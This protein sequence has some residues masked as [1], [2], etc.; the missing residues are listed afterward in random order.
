MGCWPLTKPTDEDGAAAITLK[1]DLSTDLGICIDRNLNVLNLEGQ[2]AKETGDFMTGT[3]AQVAP[4]PAPIAPTGTQPPAPE[5]PRSHID[6]GAL[7]VGELRAELDRRALDSSGLK[8]V[9]QRR[10]MTAVDAERGGTN[11]RFRVLSVDG[12]KVLSASSFHA[13]LSTKSGFA[14]VKLIEV[15][16]SCPFLVCVCVVK[17]P[18]L[19]SVVLR[20]LQVSKMLSTLK[21]FIASSNLVTLLAF[22][23]ALGRSL[24]LQ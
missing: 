23:T 3:V 8:I 9:L 21:I 15:H 11:R 13:A 1:L 14:A 20:S 17:V 5:L 16:F 4:S 6:L 18:T 22:K 12:E 2:S 19:S 7:K 10:L 24:G